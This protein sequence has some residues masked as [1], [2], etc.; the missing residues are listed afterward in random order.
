MDPS[1]PQFEFNGNHEDAQSTPEETLKDF[2]Q[3][4]KWFLSTNAQISTHLDMIAS[5]LVSGQEKDSLSTQSVLRPTSLILEHI[6][7]RE[8]NKLKIVRSEE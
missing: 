7:F 4:F 6:H 5:K 2:M 3:F 8:L 1:P